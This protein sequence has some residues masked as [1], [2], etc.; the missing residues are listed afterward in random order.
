[1]PL[2]TSRALNP[3]MRIPVP[4]ARTIQAGGTLPQQTI[5]AIHTMGSKTPTWGGMIQKSAHTGKD[6]PFTPAFLAVKLVDIGLTTMYF[7]VFGLIAAKLMDKVSGIF[8]GED[9]EKIP[10]WQLFLEILFQLIFIG[11]V[12]YAMR[13][14]VSLIPFPLNG[15]AGFD[16]YRLKELEGGELL[17]VVLILFYKNL[18]DKV[19]YFVNKVLGIT[20]VEGEKIKG[21]LKPTGKGKK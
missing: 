2:V 8:N 16:H 20:E 7:F 1:M 11:I 15:V 19:A 12:S 4:M 3:Q 10:L 17:A 13:N 6:V 14:L 5:Q 9:Y 18:K 21:A